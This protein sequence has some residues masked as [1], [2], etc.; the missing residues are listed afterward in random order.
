[1]I[2]KNKITNGIR[3]CYEYTLDL[4]TPHKDM[5]ASI[6][7]GMT[8]ENYLDRVH[9]MCD[10]LGIAPSLEFDS[11]V[12]DLFRIWSEQ[13]NKAY[14]CIPFRFS[15]SSRTIKV[16]IIYTD[17]LRTFTQDDS[18]S[19]GSVFCVG[20]TRL[21]IGDGLGS[22]TTGMRFEGAL[23][24]ALIDWV[25]LGCGTRPA[26]YEPNVYMALDNISTSP[27]APILRDVCKLGGD[28]QD[29][30]KRT[31]GRDTVRNMSSILSPDYKIDRAAEIIADITIS[32]PG[33][34]DVYLSI[35]N[36][37]QLS[38][39]YVDPQPNDWVIEILGRAYH[40]D[41][42]EQ[43]AA[44]VQD[45][46]KLFYQFWKS[47]GIVPESIIRAYNAIGLGIDLN[48]P[49]D[50]LPGCEENIA[51]VIGRL[52]GAGY[53]YVD[54]TAVFWT[55]PSRLTSLRFELDRAYVTAS[56][57]GIVIKGTLNGHP[58]TLNTRTDGSGS[59]TIF[60]R[61]MFPELRM[62]NIFGYNE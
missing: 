47:F 36:G 38:G 40:G 26:G 8:W 6:V 25:R 31:G 35:K 27:L 19:H 62:Y 46:Y 42:P 20:C 55:D 41:T 32:R 3:G 59:N 60:P 33:C 43:I 2:D 53:W 51:Q 50:V 16:A 22:G 18:L 4:E 49:L 15:A 44:C 13:W 56:G 5:D 21:Q 45:K 24:K 7:S 39:V 29:Y 61:R 34:E 52:A 30:I 10:Q 23:Y 57:K 54:P 37:G 11:L 1:M 9:Q 12:V 17:I 28:P 58:C 48:A 14:N